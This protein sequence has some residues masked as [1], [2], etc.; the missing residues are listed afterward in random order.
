MSNNGTN[1]WRVGYSH[2]SWFEDLLR[3]HNNLVSVDRHD[4]LVFAVD[5]KT[6]GDKLSIFCCNE[7]TMGLTSVL[8]AI[9]EFGKL[10]IIYIGGGWCGYTQQA[11]DFCINQKIGLYVTD[12]MSGALWK[13]EFWS[14]HK[15]DNEGNPR[16]Y[17][18][19]EGA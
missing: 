17:I 19:S 2:I 9:R 4:D 5:R 14:Y 15:R 10:D 13:N 6:C 3:G 11:K 12:E 7:Y 8:R 16:Y 18:S 1:N